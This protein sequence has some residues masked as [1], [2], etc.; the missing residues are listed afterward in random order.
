MQKLTTLIF[1]VVF[2][3][4]KLLAQGSVEGND[5]TVYGIDFTK[6]KFIGGEGFTNPSDIKNRIFE[7][8]NM[9]LANEREKYNVGAA[10]LKANVN[11]E[12]DAV[13]E[14][15]AKVDDTKMVTY[16][17]SDEVQLSKV[18]LQKM[19]SSYKKVSRPGPG[20]VFIVQAFN[21]ASEMATVHLV[22]FDNASRK[23]ITTRK[24]TAR[25]GG[26]GL[27]NYWASPFQKIIAD[28]KRQYP[29]WGKD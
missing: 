16:N 26:F 6:A 2:S 22:F 19:V 23:I 1:I 7:Q 4:F 28:A 3:T 21:K 18:D 13:R 14:K 17:A 10:F 27:R 29:T 9:L 5:L 11:Y 25:P 20:L 15:N 12:F 8:W 24:M